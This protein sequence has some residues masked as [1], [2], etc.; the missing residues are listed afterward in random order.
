M[1]KVQEPVF[2]PLAPDSN[3]LTPGVIF[4]ANES[5]FF[6]ST[7][8]EPLTTVATMWADPEG[9]KSIL[10]FVAPQVSAARRFEFAILDN[11]QAVPADT[12]D[13]RAI[14]S[15]FKRVD[16]PTPHEYG[17]TKNRGLT[18]RIDRQAS[19]GTESIEEM[20]VQFLMARLYRNDFARAI[21]M[22]SANAANSAKTWAASDSCDPDCDVMDMLISAETASGLAP[23]RILYGQAAYR[24]RAKALRGQDHAGI[25]STAGAS[26]ADLAPIFGV[27]SVRVSG[28]RFQG[29]QAAKDRIVPSIVLA[30]FGLDK[31]TLDDASNLKRFVSPMDDGTFF[32]VHR[33][34]VNSQFLD[35]TVE[36]YSDVVLT[37]SEGIQKI[38]VS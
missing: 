37:G 20:Y 29:G 31:A 3:S 21:A 13:A 34:E 11:A 26:P 28:H 6:S 38:S 10:D 16:V 19:P 1:N 36:Q 5:R 18:I 9:L 14:G 22:L 12:D 7:F 15:D 27:D 33:H 4:L 17:A 24:L 8:S 2:I 23:N 35:L 30:F 25:S 32:R